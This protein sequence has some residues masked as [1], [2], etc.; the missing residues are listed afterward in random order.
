MENILKIQVL[1]FLGRAVVKNIYQN[2]TGHNNILLFEI[3][4]AFHHCK[5]T[6]FWSFGSY[7]NMYKALIVREMNFIL[8]L[9]QC[10]K[11]YLKLKGSCAFFYLYVDCSLTDLSP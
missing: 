1:F 9:L 3:V 7:S 6:F 8:V 5:S 4:I 10:F 11:K 2:T